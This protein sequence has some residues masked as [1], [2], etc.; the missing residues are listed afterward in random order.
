MNIWLLTLLL[1]LLTSYLLETAT[2]VLTIRALSVPLPEEFSAVYT[3][4]EYQKSQDYTKAL[5]VVSLFESGLSTFLTIAFILLGG[6]TYLDMWTR[7]HADTELL[8]GL[9]FIGTLLCLS[10]L[11]GLP[12]S[13][14][15]TFVIEE[16]FGFNRTT[17]KTF[18]FDLLKGAILAI[19]IVAPLLALILW[20]FNNTGP[21]G[22]WLC[23][24]GIII[25]SLVIQFF[26]PVLILPLFNTFSPLEDGPLRRA[27]T[28]YAH[29]EDF[30]LQGIFTMDGSKR[31]S[32]ANAFFTGL[33]KFKKIVFFDTLLEKFQPEEILAVLAHEMGHYKLLHIPKNIAASIIQQGI[34]LFCM[35]LTLNSHELSQAI[36][37][38]TPSVHTALIIFALLFIPINLLLSILLHFLSRRYEFAADEYALKSTGTCRFLVNALK[39]LCATNLTNL[40]PHPLV[41]FLH[42]THPPVLERIR[43]LQ[44]MDT[45]SYKDNY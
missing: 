28:D 20:F 37:V 26:A 31:S 43:K 3:P 35:S 18:V 22:W 30:T 25:F 1:I 40:T 21:H 11:S 16:R 42:Y 39:K 27:I 8:I 12:F 44:K 34:M 7:S 36:G 6:F 24:I 15:K 29:R 9:L 23:W 41:V 13:I 33:G 14:Y 4:A 45:K 10:F 2:S 32:K 19:L 17:I 5:T 38:H